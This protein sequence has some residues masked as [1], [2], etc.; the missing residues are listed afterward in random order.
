MSQQRSETRTTYGFRHEATGALVRVESV[1]NGPGSFACSSIRHSLSRSERHPVFEVDDPVQAAIILHADIPW[2]NSDADSPSWG[3]FKPDEVLVPVRFDVVETFDDRYREPVETRRATNDA[4]LPPVAAM[5][6]VSSSRR[7]V[8]VLTKR[9]F[10][11]LPPADAEGVEIAVFGLPRHVDVARLADAVM[12]RAGDRL[13]H[14][15]ALTAV[16][17]DEEYPIR[18][19]DLD[20]MADG[21]RPVLVLYDAWRSRPEPI[22][23][24]TWRRVAEPAPSASP[25]A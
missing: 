10:G 16:E 24:A 11:V 23:F 9:Y 21:C 1:E 3:D 6:K 13:P 22:E 4:V 20:R 7:G 14:G 12:L 2:Y 18:D 15:I 8:G 5:D 17:L 19:G 25:S